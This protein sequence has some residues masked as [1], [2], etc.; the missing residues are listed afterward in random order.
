M[1]GVPRYRLRYQSTNL[2]MP[3]GE[4]AIGR[5]SSCNLALADGLVSRRHAVIHVGPQSVV[6]ED[7]GSRN[8]VA[9]NGVRINGP[10]RIAHMDRVYIGSQELVL[11][12]AAKLKEGPRETAGY[13]VCDSCGAVN[14]TA[15]RRCGE[16]GK[17]LNSS[18]GKTLTEGSVD[19]SSHAWGAEDTRTAR[20]LDVIGGIASKAIAMGRFEEAERML[21]PHLEG[22]LERAMQSR[23]LSDSEKDD[24]DALFAGATRYALQLGQG[25]RDTKWIDW[26][27]RIHAATGRLMSAE[28]IEELH[29]LVRTTHYSKPQHLRNYLSTIQ[30]QSSDYGASERFL[31]RR[32]EGLEQVVAAH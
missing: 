29:R 31:L 6:V 32:L 11:I 13:V 24:P 1:R 16:C 4:F 26:V 21:I 22:L 18:G 28:T 30:G 2:E 25:L 12:D 9:V 20:A 10:R 23:P 3:L 17:R 8:G 19:S 15:K 7:L 14:G 27:F 5:S